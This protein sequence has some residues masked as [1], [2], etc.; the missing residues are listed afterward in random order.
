MTE[1]T[2]LLSIDDV[3]VHQLSQSSATS[4]LL[5]QTTLKLLLLDIPSTALKSI[6][7]VSEPPA[8]NQHS[9]EKSNGNNQATVET[10]LVISLADRLIDIP[11]S[12]STNISFQLPR[13]YLVPI[14]PGDSS[15]LSPT[16]ID[17]KAAGDQAT[18]RIDI[19]DH[20]PDDTI[21]TFDSILAGWTRYP[22]RQNH[23]QTALSPNTQTPINSVPPPP[24]HP[25]SSS[26]FPK[27]KASNHNGKAAFPSEGRLALMDEST[28]EICG[29][30]TSNVTFQG[31][32]I[33]AHAPPY[34]AGPSSSTHPGG[35]SSG[36]PHILLAAPQPVMVSMSSTG[37]GGQGT[38]Q[39]SA[40]PISGDG[41]SQI[42]NGAEWVSRGILAG[43]E[44][45]SS[46]IKKSGNSY[47]SSAK[48]ST[49]PIT[50]SSNTHNTTDKVLGFTK[51]ASIVS[52]KTAALVGSVLGKVG[53]QIGKST[54]I[55]RSP[56]GAPPSGARGYVHKG[57]VAFN[58]VMDSIETG[59]K[60]VL[61]T[62]GDTT[63]EVV[64]HAYGAEAGQIAHRANHAVRNVGLVYIDARGVTRRAILKSVG[65]AAVRGRMNDGREVILGSDENVDRWTVV[66]S[67]S[68]TTQN[69]FNNSNPIDHKSH[70]HNDY[71]SHDHKDHKS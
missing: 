66:P 31:P 34:P 32:A 24:P 64:T 60:K 71:K 11:L 29:E 62:A 5:S 17:K 33:T 40:I 35:S 42:L 8:Y 38:A 22:G 2:L 15:S 52:G 7:S 3:T 21:D 67:P 13:S 1:G 12:Q 45:I 54:G 37:Q 9:V 48:P 68:P 53:D 55:Q 26:G 39:V 59:G 43:S 25:S 28:G 23:N 4:I 16:E 49:T 63:T 51:S 46:M 19:A 20:I 18:I 27:E 70:H 41:S 50:F 6:P 10:W 57:L 65:K 14:L 30:L 44:V 56:T 47:L 61:Y 69:G 36:P 58:T